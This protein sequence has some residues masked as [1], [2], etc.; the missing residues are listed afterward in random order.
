MYECI[1]NCSDGI[2]PVFIAE[3]IKLYRKHGITTRRKS[4]VFLRLRTTSQRSNNNNNNSP[5]NLYFL[6]FSYEE[7]EFSV[8]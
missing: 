5:K 3:T 8:F 1:E 6:F 7:F 2:L 4:Y